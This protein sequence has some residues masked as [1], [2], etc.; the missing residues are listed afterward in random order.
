MFCREFFLYFDDIYAD[1]KEKKVLNENDFFTKLKKK[2]PDICA[3]YDGLQHLF[4]HMLKSKCPTVFDHFLFSLERC[5]HCQVSH[6]KCNTWYNF[7]ISGGGYWKYELPNKTSEPC[8]EHHFACE[9]G[10]EPHNETSLPH[11]KNHFACY[12]YGSDFDNS[13]HTVLGYDY[14]ES[15]YYCDACIYKG[16]WNG[17]ISKGN[18]YYFDQREKI[19]R[20]LNKRLIENYDV[21]LYKKMTQNIINQREAAEFLG[22]FSLYD[23]VPVI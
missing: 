7:F 14:R 8:L 11:E 6:I 18:D 4:F 23:D 2:F 9:E 15:G 3:P 16:I 5:N 12:T 10:Y 13:H 1:C 20:E 19:V 21:A 17:S 22:Q